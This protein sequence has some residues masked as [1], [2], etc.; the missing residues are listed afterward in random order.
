MLP[1]RMKRRRKDAKISRVT[2]LC[3]MTLPFRSILRV[4]RRRNRWLEKQQKPSILGT[5]PKSR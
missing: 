3:T 1:P 4:R 5:T 2:S